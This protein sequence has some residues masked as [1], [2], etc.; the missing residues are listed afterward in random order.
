MKKLINVLCV[1]V[2]LFLFSGL[3][4]CKNE[5]NYEGQVKVIFNLEG[6]KYHESGLSF[7]NYYNY[8]EGEPHLIFDPQSL[9]GKPVTKDSYSFGGWYQTREEIDGKIKYS[10]PWDF[11]NDI[12]Q[13]DELVLYAKWNRYTYVVGYKDENG[14]FITKGTYYVDEGEKFKDTKKFTN[15]NGYTLIG[16]EDVNGNLFDVASFT[17]P[18][19]A[20]EQVTIICKYIKGIFSVVNNAKELI[21][22]KN[23]NIYLNANI[24]MEGQ[25]LNFGDYSKVFMGNG[26][27]I[28]NVVI[29][30]SAQKND[31]KND[32]NDSTQ[33]SL[34]ISLFGE[35]NNAIVQDV[36]FENVSVDIK[37][38]YS[39]TYKIYLAPIAT[40]LTNSTIKNVKFTGTYVI[41]SLPDSMNQEEDVIVCEDKVYYVKDNNSIV[42]TTIVELRLK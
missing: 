16:Y 28:S 6:G 41:S 31:L 27:T 18:G 21:K 10:D 37:T 29:S 24:D 19:D 30:Y 40:Q 12:V 13:G 32:F 39:N 33:K 38:L 14:N 1:I 4:G 23:N 5:T 34:M 42:E 20:M 35:M 11:E 8:E 3:I 2:L 17:H 36:I 26:H 22:N 25:S 7:I 15:R 9:S